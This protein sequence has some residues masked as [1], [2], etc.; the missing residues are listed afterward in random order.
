MS[1]MLTVLTDKSCPTFIDTA[2]KTIDT[3][4]LSADHK[5]SEIFSQSKVF[6]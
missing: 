1:M 2:I 3:V 4:T 6:A 5:A